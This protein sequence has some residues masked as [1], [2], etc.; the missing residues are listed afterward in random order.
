MI[1]V[2]CECCGEIKEVQEAGNECPT[3]GKPLY[4]DEGESDYYDYHWI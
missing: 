1:Y 4:D 3:C 2:M